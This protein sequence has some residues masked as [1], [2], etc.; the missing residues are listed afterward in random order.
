MT[1]I[2]F[3]EK[4][5]GHNSEIALFDEEV[6]LKNKRESMQRGDKDYSL[7]RLWS[8]MDWQITDI[9]SDYFI[10]HP[11]VKPC[12]YINATVKRVFPME[13][14]IV[15]I[16]CIEINVNDSKEKSDK[17]LYKNGYIKCPNCGEMASYNSY[18]NSY[19][20]PKCYN[21]FESNREVHL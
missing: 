20:C 21:M 1:L 8:G 18:F 7:C 14:D 6:D 4:F 16:L 19:I 12:P 10:S 11:D 13:T 3:V 5:I 17:D 2:E 15:P 9:G